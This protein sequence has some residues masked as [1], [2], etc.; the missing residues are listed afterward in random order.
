MDRNAFWKM[1]E[2][3]KSECDGDPYEQAEL[4]QSALADGSPEDILAFDRH[5]SELHAASYG[6]PLWGA[7]YLINGG[8]SDDSFDYFRAWLIGQGQAVFEKALADP[9]S[10]AELEDLEEDATDGEDILA[11]A[12]DAYQSATGEDLPITKRAYPELGEDWDFDDDDEM[13]SRYP[14][15]FAKFCAD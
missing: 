1:I 12:Y 7:A 15:L 2:D 11:A 9:D 8:C 5:F 4:L 14:K 3:A 10:L 13:K 6:W